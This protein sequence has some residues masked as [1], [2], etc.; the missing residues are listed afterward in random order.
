MESLRVPLG[1][2]HPVR[3]PKGLAAFTLDMDTGEADDIRHNAIIV[4]GL[5]CTLRGA[6]LFIWLRHFGVVQSLILCH[7]GVTHALFLSTLTPFWRNQ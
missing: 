6:A 4:T 7:F 3:D 5:G 1:L 2:F